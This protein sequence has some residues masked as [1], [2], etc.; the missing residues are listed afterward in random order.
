VQAFFKKTLKPGQAIITGAEV[1]HSGTFNM[2]ETGENWVPFTSY[3]KVVC[4]IPRF[5]LGRQDQNGTGH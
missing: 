5:Y 2:S 3:Q 1:E 4:Q